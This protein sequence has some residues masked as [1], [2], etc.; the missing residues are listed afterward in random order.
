MRYPAV[1]LRVLATDIEDAMLARARRGCYRPGSLRELPETW[2][3]SVFAAN[4]DE[5]CLRERFR[6]HVSIE[7]RDVLRD[8]PPDNAF[9][10]VLCRNLAFTY[11]DE[12]GQRAVA[13]HLGRALRPGGALV[14]GRHEALPAEVDGFSSWSDAAR[15]YRRRGSGASG[16]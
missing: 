13:E 4:G 5:L 7:R 8:P 12:A 6:Q 1:T 16:A 9:D 10:L 3:T 11:F 15:V 2:R 14:L